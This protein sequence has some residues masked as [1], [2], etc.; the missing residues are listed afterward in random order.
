MIELKPN[1]TVTICGEKYYICQ[2][3]NTAGKEYFILEIVYKETRFHGDSPHKKITRI[4]T[5]S[6]LGKVLNYRTLMVHDET[7]LMQ[8]M[9][10]Q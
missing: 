1:S 8:L 7:C 6:A 2:C 4:L 10:L 5:E 3:K 9:L